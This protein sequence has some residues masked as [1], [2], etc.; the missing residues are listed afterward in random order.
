MTI[1]YRN[2]AAEATRNKTRQTPQPPSTIPVPCSP[3]LTNAAN[4]N[5]P[6]AAVVKRVLNRFR[7]FACFSLGIKG[8][9]FAGSWPFPKSFTHPSHQGLSVDARIAAIVASGRGL[10]MTVRDELHT[11]MDELPE[12]EL[13]ELRQFVNDL[14][15]GTEAEATVTAES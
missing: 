3:V 4:L 2:S 13:L 7:D 11:I 8:Y 1:R 14:K 12:E 15:A 5:P 10:A 6:G 9:V